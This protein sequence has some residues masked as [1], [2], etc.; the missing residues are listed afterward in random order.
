M[1][2]RMVYPIPFRTSTVLLE[3]IGHVDI[4]TSQMNFAS[5]T[6]Y[7]TC[8]FWGVDGDCCQVDLS[9]DRTVAAK[10]HFRWS[11]VH[12]VAKKIKEVKK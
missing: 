5:R 11:Q 12:M 9:L 3:G 1:S 10:N 6:V 2:Y 8:L 4:V 7:E